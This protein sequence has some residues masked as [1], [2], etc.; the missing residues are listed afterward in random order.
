MTTA[1]EVDLRGI[2][3]DRFKTAPLSELLQLSEPAA[4]QLPLIQTRYEIVDDDVVL[5]RST[6]LMWARDYVPGGQRDWQSS[7][8]AAAKLD[9]R[10]WKWRAPTVQEQLSI[11]DYERRDPAFD[12]SVFR[13]NSS[14]VWTSTPLAQSPF[15]AWLVYF[16]DGSSSWGNRSGG[17]FVRA[18]RVGQ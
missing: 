13:G 1:I 17:G 16:S 4:K 10:G 15:Y 3:L 14:W 8:D 5:D 6:G 11:V 2:I 9:L 12:T 7:I 18:V